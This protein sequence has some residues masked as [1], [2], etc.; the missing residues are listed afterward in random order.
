MERV[1][2]VE[3]NESIRTRAAMLEPR[4]LR[5]LDAI[6]I[7]TALD[8]MSDLEGVVTYDSRQAEAARAVTLVVFSPGA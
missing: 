4:S 1:D 6:H 2:L 7:A 5:S 8:L 3:L